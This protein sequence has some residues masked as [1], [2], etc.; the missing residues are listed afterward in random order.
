MARDGCAPVEFLV[1]RRHKLRTPVKFL[2]FF[3]AQPTVSL[4]ARKVSAVSSGS[5]LLL[6]PSVRTRVNFLSFFGAYPTETL[7]PC[8]LSAGIWL[9]SG[10]NCARL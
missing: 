2:P 5:A 9:G 10:I 4:H 8:K 3:G 7:L 6:A 1:R